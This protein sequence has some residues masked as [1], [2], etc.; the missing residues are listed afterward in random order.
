MQ[1]VIEGVVPAQELY[2]IEAGPKAPAL[3]GEFLQ[4]M[5]VEGQSFSS[6]Y[7]LL[8]VTVYHV[9]MSSTSS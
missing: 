1:Q 9:D 2:K 6:G 8:W 3:M 5:S 4:S 7:V